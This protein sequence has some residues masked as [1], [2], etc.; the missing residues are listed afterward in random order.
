M[1][2]CTN[3]FINPTML[4]CLHSFCFTCL[5]ELHQQDPNNSILLCPLCR[6]KT[7]L[8]DN[9]VDSLPKDF[10][11]NALVDEFTVQEQ[12]ME[13]HGSEVKCQAC[14]D[15]QHAAI[16]RCVD[17]DYFLC[18]DC[19]NAHQRFPVTKSHQVYM[20]AQLHSGEVNYTYRSKIREYIPVRVV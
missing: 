15:E 14:N 4:D 17:C 1:S 11:L 6:K 20:L 8:E 5:K 10:K 12:L 18:Q 3:R 13:A 19:Q 2:I 9:K 7:T 16:A